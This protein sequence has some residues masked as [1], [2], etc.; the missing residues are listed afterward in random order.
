MR[1]TRLRSL[2][3]EQIILANSDLTKSRIRNYK[4]MEERRIVFQIGIVYGTPYEK[5]AA[6]TEAIQ[7]I[8]E[9]N[10]RTRFDRCHFKSYGDYAL[11]YETVYYV[12]SPDYGVF[13]DI[14]QAIN[15]A[16][17]RHFSEQAIEFAYPT[18]TI[19]LHQGSAAG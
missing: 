8:I 5:V 19:L 9:G 2:G 15:L 10:D 16:I 7:R 1:S 6:V 3:G 12:L 11:I 4:R 13:M 17:Y 18:Q 14:Q